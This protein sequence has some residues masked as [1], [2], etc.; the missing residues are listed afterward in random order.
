[1]LN[2]IIDS[3]NSWFGPGGKYSYTPQVDTGQVS[4]EGATGSV[5]HVHIGKVANVKITIYSP[6]VDEDEW[7]WFGYDIGEWPPGKVLEVVT[8]GE[9]GVKTFEVCTDHFWIEIVGTVTLH[10]NYIITTEP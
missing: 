10:Y 4:I 2:T 9:P 8:W 5:G 7:V 3:L 1:M 6:D